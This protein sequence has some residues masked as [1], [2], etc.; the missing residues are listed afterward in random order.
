MPVRAII[1]DVAREAGVSMMTVSRVVNNKEGVSLETR[2]AVEEVILKLNY[3]PNNF[4]RGLATK[5]TG[6]LGLVVPDISNPFFSGVARGVEKAAFADGYSI[7][8]CN[9]EE[10]P[11]RE[12]D[13]LGLLL[14]KCVDG[15]VLCSSRL[16]KQ[17][18]Q[19]IL[20]QYPAAV[21]VNKQLEG[22]NVPPSVGCVLINDKAGGQMAT[23]H[24]IKSGHKVIGFLSG[25][26]VSQSSR[27]REEGY[28]QA[29]TEAGLPYRPEM[30]VPCAPTVEGGQQAAAQLLAVHPEI[31]ALFCFNDLVAVGVIQAC[32]ESD[33]AI[34]NDLAIIGYDDT[35][36]APLVTPSLT[37]CRVEREELGRLATGLL[38]KRLGGC[39]DGCEKSILEPALILRASAP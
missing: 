12:L 31:T 6:T 22:V 3:R 23:S 25:P 33:R 11:Q 27:W 20:A 16:K 5:R 2:Q 32:K 21:L 8:V 1:A 28:R 10:D 29:L 9:T 4:A 18:L 30:V 35:I 19:T 17:K 34:P 37:T 38:L 15:L 7:L 26:T 36:L 13:V 24:L 39:I 14:E